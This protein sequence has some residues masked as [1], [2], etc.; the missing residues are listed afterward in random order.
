[1]MKMCV[2]GRKHSVRLWEGAGLQLDV[3]WLAVMAPSIVRG[4]RS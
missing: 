3:P 2:K 4:W 1:M